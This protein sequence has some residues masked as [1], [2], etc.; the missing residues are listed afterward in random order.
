M[1]TGYLTALLHL[2]CFKDQTVLSLLD[3]C[4]TALKFTDKHEWIRVEENG[5]GTVGISNF[6]Q[7]SDQAGTQTRD[8][9]LICVW[10]ILVYKTLFSGACRKLWE[11]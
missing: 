5:I 10:Q 1:G 3:F 2:L 8:F 4:V 7:V 11:M 6:A 9:D